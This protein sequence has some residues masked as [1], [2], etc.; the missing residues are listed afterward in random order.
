MHANSYVYT[1]FYVLES[2]SY[3]IIKRAVRNIHYILLKRR[4][5]EGKQLS[6]NSPQAPYQVAQ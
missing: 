6:K 2:H 4:L 5:S 3:R 1:K